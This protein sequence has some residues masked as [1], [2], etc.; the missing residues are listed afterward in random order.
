MSLI[1]VFLLSHIVIKSIGTKL[2]TNVAGN[3]GARLKQKITDNIDVF[4]GWEQSQVLGRG[5]NGTIVFKGRYDGRDVAVKRI[6][7]QNAKI[8]AIREREALLCCQHP[9]VLLLFKMENDKNYT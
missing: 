9:N 7:M 4:E 1:S 6:P 2:E 3:T 5:C 8:R